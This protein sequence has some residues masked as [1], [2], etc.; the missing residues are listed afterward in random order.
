MANTAVYPKTEGGAFKAGFYSYG[1]IVCIAAL[2][3]A[4]AALVTGSLNPSD[5]MFSIAGSWGGFIGLILLSVGNVGAAIFLMYSQA[6]SFKTVFPKKIMDDCDG[7]DRTDYILTSKLNVL[8]C[9]WFIHCCHFLHNG[10]SWRHC[11][12]RLLFL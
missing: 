3:G 1:I 9:I 4:L 11:R 12:G 10:C 8:R 2:V 6:V 5:W 7:N